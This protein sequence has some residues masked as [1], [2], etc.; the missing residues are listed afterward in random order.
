[1]PKVRK[2]GKGQKRDR[3]PSPAVS[4]QS[5]E[6][7]QTTNEVEIHPTKE[8]EGLVDDAEAAEPTLTQESSIEDTPIPPIQPDVS[9]IFC[10]MK[11]RLVWWGGWLTTH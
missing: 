1:M 6:S 4:E 5:T 2:G 7:A 11:M 3:S 9:S 8:P 10:Q